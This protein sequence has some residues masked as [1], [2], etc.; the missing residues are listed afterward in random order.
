[1]ISD[2]DWKP[3]SLGL[4]AMDVVLLIVLLIVMLV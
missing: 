1:M 4:I 2:S 3:L